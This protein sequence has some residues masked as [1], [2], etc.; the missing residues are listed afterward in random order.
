MGRRDDNKR[1][2]RE[3]IER[4]AIALFRTS[5]YGGASIE[6]IAADAGVA[7]GTFYLYFPD[8]LALFDAVLD[9]VFAPVTETLAAV[10]G[11]LGRA[12]TT[13]QVMAVY[14]GMAAGLALVVLA[15]PAEVEIAFR[16]S[17]Q[18]GESGQSLRRR[19]LAVLEQVTAF[20]GDVAERGLIRVRDPRLFSLMVFGT[21]ERLFYEWMMGTPLGDPT[22]VGEEVL[23]LFALALEM[24]SQ[25]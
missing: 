16:E 10:A 25:Q 13:D 21:V 4:A 5:G 19:E 1:Q 14:R 6:Q 2:K 11:E 18:A 7:R 9:R 8:K 23:R 3:A 12:R 15:H 22:A 20:T 24:S 17:R